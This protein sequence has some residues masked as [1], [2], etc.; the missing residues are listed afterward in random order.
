MNIFLIL[1]KKMPSIYLNKF[2]NTSTLV[3]DNIFPISIK[4]N[5]DMH[6]LYKTNEFIKLIKSDY[7]Y[8]DYDDMKISNN[9]IKLQDDNYVNLKEK[10]FVPN[11]NSYGIISRA[12]MHMIYNYEYEYKEVIDTETLIKWNKYNPPDNNEKLHNK[13]I[14]KYQGNDNI[15]IS[16]YNKHNLNLCNY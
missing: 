4:Q 1:N 13:I 10:L 7:K 5:K 3:V 16:Y 9:W 11:K 2:S 14:R 12:I 15:F 8:I 6:N